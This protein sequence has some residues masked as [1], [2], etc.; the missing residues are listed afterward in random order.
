[1]WKEKGKQEDRWTTAGGVNTKLTVFQAVE[2]V[3]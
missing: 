2:D 1:M 3:Y